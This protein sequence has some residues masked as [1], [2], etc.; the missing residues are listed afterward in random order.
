M[1]SVESMKQKEFRDYEDF[2]ANP[3]KNVYC[4]RLENIEKLKAMKI[5]L[6]N[7]MIMFEMQMYKSDL[8]YFLIISPIIDLSIIINF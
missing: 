7:N 8:C 3:I 5:N 2:F 4:F 6:R 1:F